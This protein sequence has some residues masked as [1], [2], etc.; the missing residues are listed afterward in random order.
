[1]VGKIFGH[2]E[3]ATVMALEQLLGV[4]IQKGQVHVDRPRHIYASETRSTYSISLP[5][6][7]IWRIDVRFH[8][9]LNSLLGIG[10]H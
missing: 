10:E 7:W 6:P 4:E 8:I 9:R 5:A 1:M 2:H 3:G